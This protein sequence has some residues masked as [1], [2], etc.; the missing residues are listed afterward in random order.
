MYEFNRSK[1]T[2]V[3]WLKK[4]I[5]EIQI[6]VKLK[7]QD[8]LVSLPKFEDYT[9]ESSRFSSLSFDQLENKT[10]EYTFKW[11]EKVFSLWELQRYSDVHNCISEAELNYND[12]IQ[13]EDYEPSNVFT[14]I[15]EDYHSPLPLEKKP[16]SPTK[17]ID[18]GIKNLSSCFQSMSVNERLGRMAC[19][20]ADASSSAHLFRSTENIAAEEEQW[21]AM[22][23]VLDH[24]EYN[25]DSQLLLKQEATLL[26]IYHNTSLNYVLISPDVNDLQLNPYTVETGAGVS[27]QYQYAVDV[28]FDE[29]DSSEELVMLLQKLYKKWER[30]QRLLI[31]FEMPPLGKKQYYLTLELLAATDFDM[32]NLYVEFHIK[33]PEDVHCNGP[34]HGRTHISE[35]F[36]REGEKEWNFGHIIEIS[37]E[38]E[39]GS[40]PPPIQLFFEVISTDWWGRHRTEGYT[41]L[42]LALTS[43]HC[44]KQLS[45]SRPEEL[46]STAA[47]SRRF[48]IGGCHLIKDLDVLAKPQLLDANF[49]FVTTGNLCVRWNIISQ[50]PLP[51]TLTKPETHGSTS[52]SA[53]LLGA[54]AVLR[55]YR[56]AR[57]RLAVAT[58]GLTKGETIT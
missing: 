39:A 47:D 1:I 13:N 34:L 43:G 11:Q 41:Y 15:H 51:G 53:L 48:F 8:G 6:T 32:D 18:C 35:S 57:A 9:T 44:N 20:L 27:L 19:V 54:E 36:V 16:I 56:K 10:K 29:E 52:A 49:K 30:Q 17:E 24:S 21:T 4:P 45:C 31:N 42:P 25:E 28:R 12:M 37:V 5:E 2:G 33:V 46:D 50:A 3:H 40:D 55:Q 23:I 26:S 14:Y 38:I 58:E 7:P 22:H